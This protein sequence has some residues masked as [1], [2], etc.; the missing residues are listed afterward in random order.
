MCEL[1]KKGIYLDNEDENDEENN[2]SLDEGIDEH[3]LSILDISTKLSSLENSENN[4]E[5]IFD[6]NVL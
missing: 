6:E 5:E 1:H 4:N 3:S 2:S